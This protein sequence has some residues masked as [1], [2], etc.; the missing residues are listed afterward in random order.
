MRGRAGRC[1]Y[2]IHSVESA[3]R[4]LRQ[5]TAETDEGHAD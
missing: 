4:D 1:H 3:V 2:P 5:V